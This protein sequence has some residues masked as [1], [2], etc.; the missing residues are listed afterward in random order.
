VNRLPLA[1]AALALPIVAVAQTQ[2]KTPPPP[3]LVVFLTVDQMRSDYFQRFLP[4]LTGGLGRLYRRGAF[5]TQGFQD[6]AITETAPGHASVLSGRFPRHTGIVANSAG[7]LDVETPL[8]AMND[9]GASPFRFRGSTLIDW[10]RIKDWRSRALSVSR[11]DRAAILPIGRAHQT[12]V[13][14]VANGNFTTSTYYS[15]T[16]PTWLTEFNAKRLPLSF[17]GQSWTPLLPDSSYPEPDS[18]ATEGGGKDYVFPHKLPRD[19][20]VTRALAQTPMMDQLTLEVAL[21]GVRGMHLGEGPVPDL[22]QISLSTTDAVGHRY[23]PDSKELHD[24]VVRLDRYLGAFLDSLYSL[25]DSTRVIFALTADHGVAP[26][27]EVHSGR[28][29]NTG[30]GYVNIA[31]F[32][33]Y[34]RQA[35]PR[36]GVDTTAWRFSE[37]CLYVDKDKLRSGGIDPDSLVRAFSGEVRSLAGVARIDLVRTLAQRDTVRDFIARRWFHMFPD[38]VAPELVVTLKPYWYWGEPGGS[39][40]HGSVYDYDAWVPILFY[41]PGFKPGKYTNVVRVVDMAP[42]LATVLGVK[43]IEKLDGHVLWQALSAP[44]HATVVAAAGQ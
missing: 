41:G 39:A 13:W 5:F 23:G 19:S 25:R 15:D 22:L 37:G 2:T 6:H 12:A 7:V 24:Q 42:T 17:A 28:Y 35:L 29:P 40:S 10:M 20:T 8:V 27:P 18:V 33:E 34:V 31:G 36:H 38:D 4:Q 16:L 1:L 14:F 9:T 32:F 21:A 11:K 44:H 43:P 3:T 30:A 26:F